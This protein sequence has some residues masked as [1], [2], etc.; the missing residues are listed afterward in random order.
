MARSAIRNFFTMSNVFFIRFISLEHLRED[1][2]LEQDAASIFLQHEGVEEPCGAD[3]DRKQEYDCDDSHL[4]YRL[5]CRSNNPVHLVEHSFDMWWSV[6]ILHR[7]NTKYAFEMHD[8][9]VGCCQVHG[10]F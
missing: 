4:L 1:W 8:G 5:S 3:A 9:S 7:P 10:K 6:V 2:A